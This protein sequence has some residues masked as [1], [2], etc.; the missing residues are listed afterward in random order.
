VVELTIGEGPANLSLLSGLWGQ[1]DKNV[2]REYRASLDKMVPI[3]DRDPSNADLQ[4][5]TSV[6]LEKVG[7][8]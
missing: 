8:V 6:T 5:F 2:S 4:R 7:D 3:H 1:S